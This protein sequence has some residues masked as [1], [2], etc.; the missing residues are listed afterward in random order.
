MCTTFILGT[1]TAKLLAENYD[2]P[3]GHGLIATNLR[4][5]IKE[6]GREPGEAVLRWCVQYGSVTFNSFSLELPVSGMNEA[7]LVVALMWHDNGDYGDDQA[8]ARLLPL[9]WIQYQLDNYQ[10]IDEVI[11]GLN[12]VR[13]KNEGVPLHYLLLDAHGDCLLVE[14]VDGEL[15]T[16]K[17]PE[18]PILSNST[19]SL[20]LETAKLEPAN[21]VETNTSSLGVF[22]TLYRLFA[23]NK[24][25]P[26]Q[27]STCFDWLKAVSQP[28]WADLPFPW[29]D[30]RDGD[31][32]ENKATTV[33][34]I[35]FDPKS[36]VIHYKTHMNQAVQKISLKDMNFNSEAD[37]QVVDISGKTGDNMDN[38][39]VP[40]SKDINLNI[41]HKSCQIIPLS[42]EEQ[43][44]L[45][46]VVDQ[47][48]KTRTM[49]LGNEN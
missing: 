45:A 1:G 39:F 2:Y 21:K 11:G 35:V 25:I 22:A 4:G 38:V 10:S 33:W 44:G 19:Y 14:F 9:Q 40:Y 5:S 3:S 23:A 24:E 43:R 6:N 13:P 47:L 46:D 15:V 20:C 42:M 32:E 28:T 17:N 34:S 49:S 18:Y 27:P 26:S 36:K 12:S 30:N 8:F 7:G 37:Y 16:Y 31:G 41:I 29:E 48:Y